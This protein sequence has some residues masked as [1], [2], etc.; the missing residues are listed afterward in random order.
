L[1][2]YS[3]LFTLYKK[4]KLTEYFEAYKKHQE[5]HFVHLWLLILPLNTQ[6]V[7]PIPITQKPIEID[8][9][10]MQF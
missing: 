9:Q 8:H 10:N 5:E 2:T 7:V 6:Q 4:D 1:G 3:D